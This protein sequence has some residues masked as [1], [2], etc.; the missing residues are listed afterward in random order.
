ML[1]QLIVL[2]CRSTELQVETIEVN[3]WFSDA[4]RFMFSWQLIARRNCASASLVQ[5]G[6]INA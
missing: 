4:E 1:K 6:Q 5:S 2:S 3:S